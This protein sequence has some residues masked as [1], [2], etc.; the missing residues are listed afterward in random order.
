MKKLLCIVCAIV[1]ALP[2]SLLLRTPDEPAHAETPTYAIITQ[3]SGNGDRPTLTVE[4]AAFL[5][6]LRALLTVDAPCEPIS[7]RLTNDVYEVTFYGAEAQSFIITHDDLYNL[8][9]VH[10]PDGTVHSLPVDVPMMLARGLWE[11]VTFAI[12]DHHEALLQKYG[13]TAAFRHPHMPVQLPDALHASR[14]DAAALHFAWADLFLRDAGYDITPYL[15]QAVIP[16]VYTV[17]ETMPRAAFTGR[18]DDTVRCSMYAVVLEYDG[19]IIG[20]Y[21]FARSWDGSNLISLKG[22]A[23]STLLNGQTIREYLLARLPMNEAERGLAALSPEEIVRRFAVVNDP[24]LQP[25]DTL[26]Q[27]LGTASSL[28]WD[29]LS[30]MASPTG[31]SVSSVTERHPDG[32]VRIFDLRTDAGS[33]YPRLILESPETGWKV[34]SFYNTGY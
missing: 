18:A 29:P 21:L 30:L 2:L 7:Y 32:D 13:W 16:Y 20:A 6:W 4:D 19:Q 25:I 5:R 26:L 34:E 24:M 23:A 12:P 11:S 33:W 15:G 9:W 3:I 28:L 8:A 10:Q 31:Q 14:T 17:Y 1:L 27:R 22:N